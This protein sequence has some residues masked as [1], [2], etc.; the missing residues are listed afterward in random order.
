M[1][2]FDAESVQ[3]VPIVRVDMPRSVLA[4][5]GL[6]VDVNRIH[7]PVKADL[8]IGDDGMTRAIRF[9]STD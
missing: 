9:V 4:S 8:A 3:S 6:P 2:G 7:E 5:F 1:P